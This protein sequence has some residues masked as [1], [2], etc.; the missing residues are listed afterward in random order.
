M[1]DLLSTRPTSDVLEYAERFETDKHR[2]LMHNSELDDVFFVQKFIDGLKYNI[3]NAIVLHKPRTV[4]AALSLA[5][6]CRKIYWSLLPKG[7]VPG[8]ETTNSLQEPLLCRAPDQFLHQEFWSKH[9]LLTR[10]PP[11]QGGMINYKH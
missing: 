11:N 7:S 3:S 10:L 2:V 9:L 5:L 8:I 4:D 6:I 1:R